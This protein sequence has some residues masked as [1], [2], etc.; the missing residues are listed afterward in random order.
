S[1]ESVDTSYYVGVFKVGDVGDSYD[2]T[3]YYGNNPLLAGATEE[4]RVALAKRD[5]NSIAE[6][7]STW[8]EGY[9]NTAS[10]H[11]YLPNQTGTEYAGIVAANNA[12]HFDGVN[13]VVNLPLL[14]ADIDSISM[15]GWFN[16]TAINP[17]NAQTLLYNGNSTLDGFGLVLPANSNEISIVHGISTSVA[18]GVNLP[19]G[20]W[21][22]IAYAEHNGRVRL[23]VNGTESY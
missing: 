2:V 6:W 22:H 3:Y 7:K 9:T 13:D 11:I 1:A 4:Y 23:F 10:N 5:N 17:T 12:L 14:Y 15:E 8:F 21:T 19:I 18:T 20:T 16:L